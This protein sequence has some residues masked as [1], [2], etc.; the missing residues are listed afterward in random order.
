MKNIK[1]NREE[2]YVPNKREQNNITIFLFFSV[3]SSIAA[4]ICSEGYIQAYLIKLGFDTESIRNYGI[5]IQTVPIAAYI[6]FTLLPPMKKG[7]KKIYATAILFT[8]IFPLVLAMAGYIS[9]LAA[10]YTIILV[11]AALYG[12]LM[13]FRTVAEYIVTPYLFSRDLYGT[14]VS[15]AMFIGGVIT[16]CISLCAGFLLERYGTGVYAFLFCVPVAALSLCT[17]FVLL[18]KFDGDESGEMPP[19]I[20]YSNILRT[21]ISARYMIKLSPHFLRGV[22]MAGIYY[23]IPSV[24][25]NIAFSDSEMSFLIVISVGATMAG[26]FLFMRFNNKIKSGMITLTSIIICSVI[27]PLLVICGDKYLFFFLYFLFFIFNIVSQISIPTGVL[28]STPNDELSLI[29]SMR[30]LLMGIATSLFIFVF[31]ILMK[32]IAAMYIML[33]SGII[34]ILCGFLYKKQFND[35]L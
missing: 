4:N 7:L 24:F 8:S 23:I 15:K 32:Y 12:F 19:Y 14:A 25:K 20:P 3:M 9:S 30:F 13:A 16:I 27:M 17:F 11:A 10:L 22:A 35:H 21:I 33:F 34:F 2:I 1:I 6:I 28:R 29:T 5:I 31:D 26:S 18:Y